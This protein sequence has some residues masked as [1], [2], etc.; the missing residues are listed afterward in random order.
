[1]QVQ[2]VEEG[3]TVGVPCRFRDMGS[4]FD[5]C[6]V[7]VVGASD[8][9]AKWGHSVGKTLLSAEHRRS[10]YLVSRSKS[11]IYGR[12]TYPSFADLPEPPEFV[13][14]VVPAPVFDVTVEEALAAGARAIVG[15][16]AGLAET[17][18]DGAKI[19]ERAAE[20]VRAAGALML[21]PN[22]Y[23]VI[24]TTTE[25]YGI[26]L[27][28]LQPGDVAV[29]AQSGNIVYDL[30][31]RLRGF[32]LGFSR[33]VSVG[34]QADVRIADVLADC[35][36]HEGTRVIA[37]YCEDFSEGRDFIEAARLAQAAGKRVVMIASGRTDRGRE[38]ALAHTASS[39]SD[40]DV[41]DAA[42]EAAGVFRAYTPR[43]LGELV[44]ALRTG[45]YPTGR[46]VAIATTGGGNGVMATDI[47]GV[48]GLEVP[49][50]SD[51][52]TRR[53]CEVVPDNANARNPID[54]IG[55]TLDDSRVFATIADLLLESGEVDNVVFTG[56][57]LAN[58][59]GFN[60]AFEQR[61]IECA[62][63]LAETATRH[64]RPVLIHTDQVQLPALRAA[65]ECGVPVYRDIESA[66]RVLARLLDGASAL[67]DELPPMPSP[68]SPWPDAMTLGQ[69][70]RALEGAG[71]TTADCRH[72]NGFL[73]CLAAASQIGYPVVVRFLDAA[74]ELTPGMRSAVVSDSEGLRSAFLRLSEQLGFDGKGLAVEPAVLAA[75][76]IPWR[77]ASQWDDKFGPLVRLEASGCDSSPSGGHG[78]CRGLAPLSPDGARRLVERAAQSLARRE[79]SSGE[80]G[81]LTCLLRV[82]VAFSH[83]AAAHPEISRMELEPFVVTRDHGFARDIRIV[84]A[85]CT[86]D[87]GHRGV[88][89]ES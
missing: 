5:P 54:M 14:V 73:D 49:R 62:P 44:Y 36:R 75:D 16:T 26:P 37:I 19:Q 31:M 21:G 69:A 77:I 57:P 23:G 22:C 48:A 28:V 79:W 38:A 72:V 4:L 42:C 61:E 20:A 24:D 41:V 13:E 58:W 10:V 67:D 71:I 2:D 84:P 12:K 83:L 65:M 15:I 89:N 8:D 51:E 32:G 11:T 85:R 53:V 60:E 55:T 43:Q 52:L 82:L 78:S 29:I 7:A 35:A 81:G 34:N 45:V 76:G 25:L 63:L 18:P 64:G 86:A 70:L 3:T 1:M 6:S 9:P 33:F 56:S 74:A 46:K 66:A 80:D 27:T 30:R 87:A 88:R 39:T 40:E 68:E 50:F 17:G 59:H 47:M